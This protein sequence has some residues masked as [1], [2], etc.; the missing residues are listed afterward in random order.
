MRI[1]NL[2]SL[3]N[4]KNETLNKD[5][6][7]KNS[8]I[9]AKLLEK[10]GDHLILKLSN[11]EIIKAE[12]KIPMDIDQNENMSF[13]VKEKQGETIYIKPILSSEEKLSINLTDK[14]LNEYNLSK[15][16]ENITLIKGLINLDMNISKEN[17]KYI[18]NNINALE[19]LYENVKEE[20]FVKSSNDNNLNS[21][22]LNEDLINLIDGKS[23]LSNSEKNIIISFFDDLNISNNELNIKENTIKSILFLIKNNMDLNIKN[24]K[25]TMDIIEGKNFLSNNI[26]EIKNSIKN[27]P[28]FKDIERKLE[29][30]LNIDDKI[31][32]INSK[33]TN[34]KNAKDFNNENAKDFIKDYYKDISKLVRELS[35]KVKENES[36]SSKIKDIN[37]EIKFIKDINKNMDFFYMPINIKNK[38]NLDKIYMF[39]KNKGKLSKDKIKIYFSLNT[40][41]LDKLDIIY[42]VIDSKNIIKFNCKNKEIKDYIDENKGRLDVYLESINIKNT[43]IKVD[44]KK[45][46]I[47]F[48]PLEDI[49][50]DNYIFDARV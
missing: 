31:K 42:E 14:I 30:I 36:L 47:Y 4:K 17:I 32:D 48:E 35:T 21:N 37:E 38:D 27:N 13:I 11:G 5:I 12:T 39:N 6:L 28:E 22:I 40:L 46:D 19:I 44:I 7:V 45:E 8:I 25:L 2:Y 3:I 26:L 41:N 16:K 33:D 50:F 9:N 43:T 24:L 18:S 1:D 49:D 10:S 23:Q 29:Y 34:N 15:N 20:S